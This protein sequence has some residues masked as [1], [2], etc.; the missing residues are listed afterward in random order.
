MLVQITKSLV[1][2]RVLYKHPLLRSRIIQAHSAGRSEYHFLEFGI[3]AP[4][5][6]G[7][8]AFVAPYNFWE[9]RPKPLVKWMDEQKIVLHHDAETLRGDL[10]LTSIQVK[11]FVFGKVW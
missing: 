4:Q 2:Y 5:G 11:L 7:F 6:G 3:K 10:A 8:G 9:K 1:P